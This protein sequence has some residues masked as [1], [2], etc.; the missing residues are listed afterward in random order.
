MLF[1]SKI[2][3]LRLIKKPADRIID[4]TSR[5]V[6]I[7]RGERAEFVGGRY[8]TIDPDMI[9][10]LKHHQYYGKMF[11]SIDDNE[12][13]KIEKLN[14]QIRMIQGAQGVEAAAAKADIAAKT[15]LVSKEEILEA[16]DA[17]INAAMADILGAI[18]D[19][20]QQQAPAPMDEIIE[21][22][23]KRKFT[24]PAP[25]CGEVFVSGIEV[26]KHKKEKHP[27]LYGGK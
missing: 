27:E 9:D 4:G 6:V 21:D 18:K 22:R 2:R 10:W 7:L 25:G 20:Q 17:K 15:P 24:C 3:D 1:V 8:K 5:Q 23:P 26:G 14:E 16:V 19:L 11:T 12:A 13:S